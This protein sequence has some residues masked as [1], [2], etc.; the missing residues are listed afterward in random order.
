V[1]GDLDPEMQILLAAVTDVLGVIVGNTRLHLPANGLAVAARRREGAPR[2]RT[3]CGK[4]AGDV[5]AR[6]VVKDM[7]MCRNCM[8]IAANLVRADDWSDYRTTRPPPR[9]HTT[10]PRF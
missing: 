4:L 5:S 10:R 3:L 9:P 7:R 2:R 6:Q 1:P 8:H